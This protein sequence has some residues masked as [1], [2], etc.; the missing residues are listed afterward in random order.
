MLQYLN[1]DV[2]DRR[3][4]R[5]SQMS[6]ENARGLLGP[7]G[8]GG[9]T[10]A[11]RGSGRGR[12][13]ADRRVNETP[14]FDPPVAGYVGG[15]RTGGRGRSEIAGGRGRGR[16][17]GGRGN[18]GGR[19]GAPA[20]S[21]RSSGARQGG[22]APGAGVHLPAARDGAGEADTREAATMGNAS[23]V[24]SALS[25]SQNGGVPAQ[26]S[27]GRAC[28][29]DS[30]T[31]SGSG[32]LAGS[33]RAAQFITD[34]KVLAARFPELMMFSDSSSGSGSSDDESE[35]EGKEG[36]R[37][38]GGEREKGERS[39]RDESAERTRASVS[40]L[41][42]SIF[43]SYMEA[44]RG[45]SASGGRLPPTWGGPAVSATRVRAPSIEETNE[46]GGV[47]SRVD[48]GSSG[49][50]RSS[51][52]GDT[53]VMGGDAFSAG[54]EKVREQLHAAAVGGISCLICLERVRASDPIWS[55]R[56][57]CHGILHLLCIQAW[58]RQ[59]KGGGGGG[60]GSRG[61]S[62][63][64]STATWHCP[65]CRADY[66]E[67]EFPRG[68]EC[69]CGRTRDPPFD[70]WV[71][72]HSCGERCG[73]RLGGRGG[74][75]G[76]GIGE[77]SSSGEDG[78]WGREEGGSVGAGDASADGAAPRV[79]SSHACAHTCML[80]C[81]PGPCP[82]CPQSVTATCFCGRKEDSRRCGQPEFSCG[83]TCGK[84]L[85]CGVHMCESQCHA[86]PCAGCHREGEFS[87]RCGRER[88]R[89]RCAEREFG[90]GGVCGGALPC[91][92]HRCER[93]CH[94]GECGACPLSGRK[95]CPCGK[96]SYEGLPCDK[97][98]GPCGGTCERQLA[99]GRHRCAERC[100]VGP[101]SAACRIVVVK[102]CRCGGLQKQ[103]I[104]CSHARVHGAAVAPHLCLFR[105]F[106]PPH[107]PSPL[108]PNPPPQPFLAPIKNNTRSQDR[109]G[110]PSS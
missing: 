36:G 77:S 81:H 30:A 20:A 11:V 59:T 38:D 33:Q 42:S 70:P 105:L 16:S 3:T 39:R 84:L 29:S 48:G 32:G 83:G 52:D 91:G 100:H 102:S 63:A 6:D 51:K 82:P 57:G 92:K 93:E 5:K 66:S 109:L 78:S 67:V 55:C 75:E 45:V 22:S 60:G 34:P 54:M 24:K 17:S 47:D 35:N 106:L 37:E 90:C 85:A 31:S 74:G 101:C 94:A 1:L 79:P 73:R 44:G 96:K 88:A 13:A 12:A 9:W 25:S 86:G 18:E 10:D 27:Q 107:P 8:E 71:T 50:E 76:E 68:Y 110:R 80:L 87:C 64:Q 53:S 26:Q 89:R 40:A 21:G 103:V 7:G 65:K 41:E 46:R 43:Q 58:A 15:R 61:G 62:E 72:P 99:C 97:R 108:P 104:G 69:F 56:R 98:G 14:R 95:S 19:F 49:E 23:T 4:C 2:L 28:A